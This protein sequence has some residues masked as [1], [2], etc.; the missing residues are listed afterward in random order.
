L[1]VIALLV[2]GA[3]QGIIEWIP[4]SS[5]GQILILLSKITGISPG[6]AYEYSL[7]LHLG[8]ALAALTFYRK[9]I[10]QA[11][12]EVNYSL[13]FRNPTSLLLT[14]TPACSFLVAAPLFLLIRL[15]FQ[16]LSADE[17]TAIIGLFLIATG[18]I[19]L[20]SSSMKRVKYI[21][22]FSLKE[23]ILLGIVQGLSIIPGVSRSA[24]TIALLL[25]LHFKS[26]DAFN[27]SFIA[28]IPVTFAAGLFEIINTASPTIIAGILTAFTFGLITMKGMIMISKKVKHHALLILLG[29]IIIA[30]YIIALI[31]QK[32]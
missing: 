4:I 23:A 24:I 16:K 30:S 17:I 13:K 28:A 19:S 11:L 29:T 10:S 12:R 3:I 18:L 2:I 25:G 14:V 31:L 9:A 15:Q 32:I 26:E 6:L 27:A 5:S 20:R 1:E 21:S 8:T 22:N 7:A